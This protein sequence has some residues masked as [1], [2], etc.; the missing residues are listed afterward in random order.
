[1]NAKYLTR[2]SLFLRR[3]VLLKEVITWLQV[4]LP[5]V[6]IFYGCKVLLHYQYQMNCDLPLKSWRLELTNILQCFTAIMCWAEIVQSQSML[7]RLSL[8]YIYVVQTCN[9]HSIIL[10]CGFPFDEAKSCSKYC[11][12][13]LCI[14]HSIFSCFG[15]CWSDLK[16]MV[17][18]KIC[19]T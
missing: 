13:L 1:M 10:W 14:H 11:G 7:V 19:Y 17:L 8:W 3:D 18:E 9:G 4:R 5:L 2:V 6:V 15:S 12:I 16:G